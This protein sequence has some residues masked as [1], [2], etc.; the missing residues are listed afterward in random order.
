VALV[1]TDAF[2]VASA[3]GCRFIVVASPS[4]VWV[5]LAVLV[6]LAT[7]AGWSALVSWGGC[8]TS[9]FTVS[10]QALTFGEYFNEASGSSGSWV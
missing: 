3:V 4:V 9:G 1:E 5:D 10:N 8:W 7:I 2:P 6:L